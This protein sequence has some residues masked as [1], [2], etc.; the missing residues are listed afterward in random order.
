MFANSRISSDQIAEFTAR[1][2]VRQPN[3]GPIDGN[4]S[5][6]MLLSP[7]R[8]AVE[9]PFNPRTG[10]AMKVKDWFSVRIAIFVVAKHSAI[11][12]GNLPISFV[13]HTLLCIHPFEN[14][15]SDLIYVGDNCIVP[16]FR[17]GDQRRLW[18]RIM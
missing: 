6:L 14:M 16:C 17:Y 15:L 2:K 18:V 1:L 9:G 5:G 4:K 8:I 3:S 13:S 10:C 11:G 7:S 12:E